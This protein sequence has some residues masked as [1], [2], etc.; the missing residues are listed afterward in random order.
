MNKR[1]IFDVGHPAQVHNFKNVYW[2][3]SKN[4]WTGLFTAKDKE[5]T[6]SLLKNY[7][8]PYVI[9]GKTGK[10][11]IF[12][13]IGLITNF[14]NFLKVLLKFKPAI[15]ICR[16]SPHAIWCSTLLRIPVIGLADTEHTKFLDCITVPLANVKLTSTS[17]EK[18]LGKNHIRF[19]G[20]IELFYLHPNRYKM[21]QDFIAWLNLSQDQEYVLLRFVSWSA[22]HDIGEKG[23]S[24]EDKRRLVFL[25]V[26]RFKVFISS[27]SELPTDLMPYRIEVPPEKMHDI[28]A[29]ASLYVGEGASMASEA[30]C[31]GVPSVYVNTLNAGSLK[32][33]ERCGLIYNLRN[34]KELFKIFDR[35]VEDPMLKTRS[36][37]NLKLFLKEKIDVTAF[38]VW[39]IENFPESIKI[40][41]DNP[42]YQ[43]RF[44]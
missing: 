40:M 33:E 10:N 44:K 18:D 37:E 26:K 7:D 28:L 43:K 3:L 15:V 14:V 21:S 25:L 8:L 20:N 36:K 17:Y 35:F 12:K 11:L 38:L 5:V 6:L 30:A 13:S 22:Y 32:E 27:E 34:T 41:K 16:S 39:F 19:Y 2:E 23:F 24:N 42:E 29:N 9:I 1:I 31:L 4:G